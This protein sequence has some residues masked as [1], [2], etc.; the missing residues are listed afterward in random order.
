MSMASGAANQTREGLASAASAPLDDFNLRRR[1]I[2]QLV[3]KL[4]SPYGPQ[5]EMNCAGIAMDVAELDAVLGADWD[6]G[7]PDERLAS[8]VLADEASNAALDTVRSVS[9]GWI[10]F[11]GLVRQA[12]GAESHEKKYNQAFK[13]GAQRRAYLKGYGQALGCPLPAQPDFKALEQLK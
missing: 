13:I 1:E 4:S 12:T 7:A 11:R 5:S 9:T 3:A 8:E 2:P 6:S 10:P